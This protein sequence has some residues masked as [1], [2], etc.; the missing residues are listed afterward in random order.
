MSISMNKF[1]QFNISTGK[2]NTL[3]QKIAC[4]CKAIAVIATNSSEYNKTDKYRKQ[5]LS[6]CGNEYILYNIT[7]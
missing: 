7:N 1:E 4:I 5:I 2:Y 6:D 3:K